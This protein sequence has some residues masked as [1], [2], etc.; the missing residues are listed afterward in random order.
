MLCQEYLV[1]S[2]VAQAIHELMTNADQVMNKGHAAMKTHDAW[3]PP[4]R[5]FGAGSPL[6]PK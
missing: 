6:T 5:V 3:G 1:R 2:I 4:H